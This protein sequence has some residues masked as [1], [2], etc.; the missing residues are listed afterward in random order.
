MHDKKVYKHIVV[1]QPF[2]FY[3]TEETSHLLKLFW[4]SE[5][6]RGFNYKD[7]IAAHLQNVKLNLF[8]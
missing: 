6:K 3:P 1:Y 7:E 8:S 2:C 4:E 5:K